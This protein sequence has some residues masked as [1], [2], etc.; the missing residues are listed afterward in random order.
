MGMHKSIFLF[1]LLCF[2]SF[3][4][5]SQNDSI[6]RNGL[7]LQLDASNYK[8]YKHYQSGPN[9][10]NISSGLIWDDLSG[11]NNDGVLNNNL[12]VFSS[13]YLGVNALNFNSPADFITIK[14]S[15]TLNPRE[16]ITLIVW[17]K[18]SNLIQNQNII[19]KGYS[20]FKLPYVQYSLKMSDYPPYNSPQFNLSIDGELITLNA[21]TVLA[22]NTWY[23]ISCTY[24]KNAMKLFIN[25][26]QD[27]IIINNSG[28]IDNYITNLEVGRWPTG[29]SQNLKGSINSIYVYNR[30]LSVIELEDIWEKTKNKLA[31]QGVLFSQKEVNDNNQLLE[32]LARKN[33]L[34]EHEKIQYEL[35]NQNK[36]Q[37]ANQMLSPPEIFKG[38]SKVKLFDG[39]IYDGEFTYTKINGNIDSTSIKMNGLGK[40][41]ENGVLLYEGDVKNNLITGKGSIYYRTGQVQTTGEYKNGKL[42]GYGK[43]FNSEGRLVYEGQFVENEFSGH[44]KFYGNEAGAL[45][46]EGEFLSGLFSG[47]GKY[48]KNGALLFEGEFENGKIVSKVEVNESLSPKSSS[49]AVDN[50]SRQSTFDKIYSGLTEYEKKYFNQVL[51]MSSDPNNK[52][53]V[54]CSKLYSTCYWCSKQFVY[55]KYYVSKIQMIKDMTDI[56]STLYQST[57]AESMMDLAYSLFG[58]TKAF[59]GETKNSS[60]SKWIIDLKN[61]LKQIKQGA[62]YF[63]S[64]Y[65]PKFCSEKCKRENSIRRY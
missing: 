4:S 25:N 34:S 44:G 63:C 37:Y 20:D 39:R 30:A 35:A 19:S 45:E 31:Y 22:E 15:P 13:D 41:F 10:K 6:S 23:M 57:Y 21:K 40:I 50:Q 47:K 16:G 38:V 53:G 33:N 61:D 56:N 55:Y 48:Y 1:V 51:E 36:N 43:Y 46:Y 18:L 49:Q 5:F 64:G 11:K 52:V 14:N 27:P 12:D 42:N 32:L 9:K 60:I 58:G 3:Y 59:K 24:D 17:V 28:D 26:K 7:V 62:Y 65:A 29:Q 54:S 2:F 8:P